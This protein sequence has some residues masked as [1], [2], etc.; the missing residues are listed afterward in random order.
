MQTKL[1]DQEFFDLLST[2]AEKAFEWLF[3]RYFTE[4]CQVVYRVTPDEHL[5]QDLVQEV[6][7]ELWRKRDQLN[8]ST[9]LRAY[10]KR[11]VLNRT[12]N[13]L[14][15]NRKWSTE[16]RMPELADQE[17][18]PT[19]N[20]RAEELQK[21]VDA[22][23]DELPERC[24]MVFVLSRYEELSYR[25]IATELGIAEKTVENQVSKALKY[26]RERLQPFLKDGLFL[27]I[28]WLGI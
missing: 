2:N 11:A 14:R 6:L 10:L 28:L 1:N 20:L 5:A 16:E 13:H 7:Y 15:D 27:M 22:A 18:D 12:L 19:E 26:L 24:R 4:L 23:I 17:F 3:R 21:R 9:S 25:D 8:I